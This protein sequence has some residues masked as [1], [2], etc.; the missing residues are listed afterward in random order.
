MIRDVVVQGDA[1]ADFSYLKGK[2]IFSV[3]LY[4]ESA[5][6]QSAQTDCSKVQMV[7]ILP[8]RVFVRFVRRKP[9]ALIKLGEKYFAVDDTGALFVMAQDPGSSGIPVIIGLETKI[10]RPRAGYRY[11][12]WELALALQIIREAR[13]ARVLKD[14][15]VK[16][17]NVADPFNTSVAMAPVSGAPDFLEIKLGAENIRDKFVVFGHLIRQTGVDIA[18]I[19]YVDMRFKD[20]VMKLREPDKK[21]EGRR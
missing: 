16:T 9:S 18:S 19:K 17:I 14:F 6:T 3:D 11:T 21:A 7:R 10:V 13:G 8:G 12:I 15:C 1:A 20:P 2:N 4:G 5:R